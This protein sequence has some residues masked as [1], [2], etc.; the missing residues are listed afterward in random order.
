MFSVWILGQSSALENKLTSLTENGSVQFW[1]VILYTLLQHAI[2]SNDMRCK[3]AP[4][5]NKLTEIPNAENININ[6]RLIISAKTRVIIFEIK[7]AIP[8]KIVPRNSSMNFNVG[9]GLGSAKLKISGVNIKTMLIAVNW[10]KYIMITAIRNGFQTVFSRKSLGFHVRLVA[11]LFSAAT[12]I[13]VNSAVT[14]QLGPRST[15]KTRCARSI[16]KMFL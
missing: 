6:L 8:T 16:E 12:L 5:P 10:K 3:K 4:I 14:F 15:L 2:F 13:S 11:L 1:R 9:S 7:S